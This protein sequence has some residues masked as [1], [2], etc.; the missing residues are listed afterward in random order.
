M[1]GNIWKKVLVT[2]Y[3]IG[4]MAQFTALVGLSVLTA[5]ASFVSSHWYICMV[6]PVLSVLTGLSVLADP[7][8]FVSSHWSRQFLTVHHKPVQGWY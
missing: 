4:W 1:F 7:A 2:R 6:V 8:H 5:P 3:H